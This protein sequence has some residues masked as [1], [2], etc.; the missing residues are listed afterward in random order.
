L[1]QRGSLTVWF[2]QAANGAWNAGT[3]AARSGHPRYSTLAITTALTLQTVFRLAR[4]QTGGLIVFLFRL[5]GLDLTALDHSMI[6]RRGETMRLQAGAV[7]QQMHW[8]AALAV[9]AASGSVISTLRAGCHLY[10]AL[11]HQ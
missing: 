9:S 5:L 6:S 7:H 11:T 4:G 1:R 10:L 8:L 3:H 2:T